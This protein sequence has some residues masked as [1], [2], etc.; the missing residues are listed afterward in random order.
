MKRG[1]VIN[2]YEIL[3][4]FR[5][6]DAGLSKWTFAKRG[7]REYF[8]KE[9]LFPKYP[10]PDG[11][12]SEATKEKKRRE[13]ALFESRQHRLIALTRPVAGPGGNLIVTQDFFRAGCCYYKVTERV[14]TSGFDVAD[15]AALPLQDRFVILSAIAFSVRILHRAGIVHG[16]L[17]PANILIKPTRAGYTAKLIDFDDA[18]E[19]G[20]PPAPDAIVGT[21]NYYSPEVYLY[22]KGHV[23][24][25]DLGV[26]ADV[27]SLGIVFCEFLTAR[28]PAYDSGYGRYVG[29]A[30]AEGAKARLAESVPR[31]LAELVEGMLE[32]Q[33]NRRPPI[34][35]VHET[36]RTAA[37]SGG[38]S[39]RGPAAVEPTTGPALRG[40]GLHS[41]AKPGRVVEPI[42]TEPATS[43]ED[44]P[45]RLKG[46]G[47]R[48]TRSSASRP[49][50]DAPAKPID[51]PPSRLKGRGL[52]PP[53]DR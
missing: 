23:R 13:C 9:F 18:Y 39:A 45:S 52:R 44:P 10:L 34:S 51:E 32:G 49:R 22:I 19:A 43:S 26:A 46:K 53:K 20:D 25:V 21:M 8:I 38:G 24:P 48:I 17:K 33:P 7:G 47:L 14:E 27:F 16:D 11:P 42:T 30:V 15:A 50:D 31:W 29:P 5:T 41:T 4:D 40:R 12:G 3:E 35:T 6:T 36:L 28:M 37:G 1:R 2:G